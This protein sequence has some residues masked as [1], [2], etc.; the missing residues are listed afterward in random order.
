MTKSR[1]PAAP[2]SAAHIFA[3]LR[4]CFKADNRASTLWSVLKLDKSDKVIFLEGE[5]LLLS[6]L[7]QALPMQQELESEAMRAKAWV[8]RGEKNLIY[9]SFFVVGAHVEHMGKKIPLCAPIF[10]YPAKIREEQELTVSL[11]ERTLNFPLIELLCGDSDYA[12]DCAAQIAEQLPPGRLEFA[13]AG[14]LADILRETSPHLDCDPLYLYPE[15]QS[16]AA[17]RKRAAARKQGMS[18]LPGG[19]LALVKKSR[20][21]RGILNELTMMGASSVYSPPLAVTL[22][23]APSKSKEEAADIEVRNVP[24]ILSSAQSAILDSAARNPLSL[25]IGPPGT[26]KSFTIAAI[27]LEHLSRGQS[28]LIV[29]KMNHAV[30]VVGAKIEE[31]LQS[32]DVVMRGGRKDY[33]KRLVARFNDWLHGGEHNVEALERQILQLDEDIEALNSRIAMLEKKFSSMNAAENK[34]AAYLAADEGI[35]PASTG[36]QE[37]LPAWLHRFVLPWVRFRARR[38]TPQWS[39]LAELESCMNRRHALIVQRIMLQN[40]LRVS[41]ALRYHRRDIVNFRKSLTARS[42]HNQQRY[43]SSVDKSAIIDTFPVWLVNLSDLNEVLPLKEEL[44]DVVIIDEATQ[45]DIAAALPAMQRGRRAVIVGDPRQLR[46][47]SFLSRDRQALIAKRHGL[48]ADETQLFNYRENSILDLMDESISDQR[49]VIPLGEHFRSVPSIIRFSNRE[50]Y[51]DSLR[52]MTERPHEVAAFCG[53]QTRIVAGR[54]R[55]NGVNTEEAEALIAEVKQLIENQRFFN[56]A[57][58]YSIGILS[59]FRDQVDFLRAELLK[60]IPTSLL[61]RHKVMIGTSHTFQGEERDVMFLSFAVCGQTSH[62]AHYF[63]NKADVF[64]VAVTR[65]RLGQMVYTS[66]PADAIKQ[67][68]LLKKYLLA[69]SD[70]GEEQMPDADHPQDKFLNRVCDELEKLELRYYKAYPIAGIIIDIVLER[71]GLCYGIDLIGFPGAFQSRIS[72]ERFRLLQRAGLSIFPL[73]FSKWT[74]ERDRCLQDLKRFIHYDDLPRDAKGAL[75]SAGKGDD[76]QMT[77]T[78]G[79]G[80][81]YL[82]KYPGSDDGENIVYRLSDDDESR[83]A[84]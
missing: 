82:Y 56:A 59:P 36:S 52:I 18:V 16:E 79:E 66:Q 15:L 10:L 68:T 33:R 47:I 65:A 24:A 43:L 34:R 7:V 80:V 61:E 83:Q 9:A 73:P 12:M 29:S 35:V 63:L 2:D 77:A 71:N 21:S 55:R 30:D 57:A 1:L 53:V 25:V 46:F 4:D 22:G 23:R 17:L 19:A 32:G 44:F 81:S 38:E 84:K 27:A 62:A 70:A 40:K 11:E 69:I 50:F 37:L 45:C 76:N 5:E 60:Q 3:Y 49:Q 67:D 58:S 74:L 13:E 39:V 72:L 48:N 8:Q 75:R 64:N 78:L 6:G 41:F 42:E 20:D 31:Q 54:R 14:R 28:V 26:G 51:R